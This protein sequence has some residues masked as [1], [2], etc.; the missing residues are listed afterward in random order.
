MIQEY[1][2]KCGEVG[3]STYRTICDR[4][5]QQIDDFSGEVVLNC[6]DGKQLHLHAACAGGREHVHCAVCGAAERVCHGGG[7]VI[8]HDAEKHLAVPVAQLEEQ[9]L[10]KR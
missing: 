4:C 9:P 2:A 10:P 8:V 3:S 6:T 7:K 1:C 5:K